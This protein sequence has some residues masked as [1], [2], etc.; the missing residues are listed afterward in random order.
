MIVRGLQ[1]L[2]SALRDSAGETQKLIL[3][4]GAE[5][6]CVP[7]SEEMSIEVEIGPLVEMLQHV[8]RVRKTHFVTADNTMITVDSDVILADNSTARPRSGGAGYRTGG[9]RGKT[10]RV[11]KVAEDPSGAY[12]KIWLGSAK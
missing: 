8:V 4:S 12:F 9:F 2:E 6:P 1:R 11:L 10:Y 3:P 7:S 5:I